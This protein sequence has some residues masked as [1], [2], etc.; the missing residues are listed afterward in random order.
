MSSLEFVL[1]MEIMCIIYI[2][3][4]SAMDNENISFFIT[5]GLEQSIFQFIHPVHFPQMPT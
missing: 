4:G 3:K 2:G 1:Y 5:L